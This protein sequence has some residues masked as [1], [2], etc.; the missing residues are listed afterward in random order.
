L[1]RRSFFTSALLGTAGFWACSSNQLGA[2][3]LRGLVAES[4]R[5]IENVSTVPVPGTWP[6]NGITACWLGHASVLLNFYGVNI[7]TDP[8]MFRRVGVDM[9]F[10]IVGPKRYVAPALNVHEL[11]RIDLVLL[12]HA[13][14]DHF[15]IPSLRC[16]PASTQV[17]TAA[18]TGD[19]LHRTR[20]RSV[21]E[22]PWGKK[23]TLNTPAG[24]IEVSSFPVQHW[25][26]RWRH[27]SYRGYAGYV[28]ARE[29][30]KI[31]FGGDTAYTESFRELSQNGPYEVAIMP[32]GAY[33][34]Y[35]HCHC[36]PEQAVQ[37]AEFAG[38]RHL[39]PIHHKTFAL[40]REGRV[41]PMQRLQS[42]LDANRIG[43]SEIGET[44][45]GS[46]A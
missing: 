44:Y 11:P 36:T 39:L 32:I 20:M 46:I 40:G 42:A 15:D 10:G 18:K 33:H 17:V 38:A 23:V 6:E 37:M 34:P 4:S 9:R 31:I 41:E 1:S 27:D 25:G 22:L 19:L 30:K 12:S 35:V 7:L 8:V 26:A 43:W 5:G 21:H 29:G 3:V 13:H 45:Y 24:S 16:L 28:L 14:M 2:R